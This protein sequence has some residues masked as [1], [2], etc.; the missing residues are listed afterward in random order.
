MF[1][2][3]QNERDNS[4]KKC[5]NSDEYGKLIVTISNQTQRIADCEINI[6]LL[7]TDV[8]NLR[9]NFNRKLS[10]I[11]KNEQEAEKNKPQETESFNNSNEV[12]FG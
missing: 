2:K 12:P 7:K 5:I 11:A 4:D 10:G 3:K 9:G 8:A 6:N 1:W